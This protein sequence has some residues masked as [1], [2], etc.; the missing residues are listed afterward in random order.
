MK[1]KAKDTVHVSN[2]R[3]EPFVEGET[4]ELEEGQARQLIERGLV[5]EVKAA[6]APANK[7]APEPK[8]KAGSK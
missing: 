4:F 1:V 5:S 8:N 6:A 2:V 7:K 3:S